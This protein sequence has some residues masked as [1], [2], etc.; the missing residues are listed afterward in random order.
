MYAAQYKATMTNTV[1]IETAIQSGDLSPIFHWLR[2]NIWSQASTHTTDELVKR[3]MGEILN[4]EYF[5]KHL[6]GRYL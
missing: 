2:D 5:K 4:A 3:A 6:E 1:D